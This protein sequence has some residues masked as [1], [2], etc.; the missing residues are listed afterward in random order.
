M[1]GVVDGVDSVA[2]DG[3]N[4][5]MF[6]NVSGNGAIAVTTVWG[7][8]GGPT[9]G[10]FLSEW[11]QMYDN[12]DFQWSTSGESGKMDFENISNHEIGHAFGMG[13]PSDTCTEETMYRYASEGETKKRD[14]NT[15]DVQGI[16]NLYK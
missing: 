1:A 2:P 3:K 7:V 11:D 10:R 13:H 12:V 15:G 16:F 14:L 5:V 9:W 8:F 6:G 4:E